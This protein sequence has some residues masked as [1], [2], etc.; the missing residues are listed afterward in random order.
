M[1]FRE[2]L[3]RLQKK[4]LQVKVLWCKDS[5]QLSLLIKREKVMPK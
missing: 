5:Q 2:L 1:V 3:V 4:E